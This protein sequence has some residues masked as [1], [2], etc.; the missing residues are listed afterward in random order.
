ML[1]GLFINQSIKS[2]WML[3]LKKNHR[4]RIAKVLFMLM[5]CIAGFCLILKAYQSSI[6]LYQTPTQLQSSP[7]LL[8]KKIRL[9]GFV[10]AESIKRNQMQLE[11]KVSDHITEVAVIFTGIPPNLFR[12]NQA[13][14]ILGFYDG[15]YFHAETILA[16]HDE[17]YQIPKGVLNVPRSK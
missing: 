5:C 17:N 10:V 13:A 4:L 15:Q 16:K 11:F 2:I 3:P 1:F 14:I 12:E 7:L 9:G 8:Q 6:D